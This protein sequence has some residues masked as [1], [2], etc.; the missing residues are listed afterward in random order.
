[1]SPEE[2]ELHAARRSEIRQITARAQGTDSKYHGDPTPIVQEICVAS[3]D[4]RS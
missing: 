3:G 2:I 4:G 1:M